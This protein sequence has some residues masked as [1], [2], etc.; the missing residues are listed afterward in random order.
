M[1]LSP[2]LTEHRSREGGVQSVGDFEDKLAGGP[3]VVSVRIDGLSQRLTDCSWRNRRS[4]CLPLP[5][6]LY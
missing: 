6:P 2:E 3:V 4:S 1:R 5:G